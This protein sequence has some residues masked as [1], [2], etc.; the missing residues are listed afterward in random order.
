MNYPGFT[1]PVWCWLR[2]EGMK[3]PFLGLPV[4]IPRFSGRQSVATMR[5]F[6]AGMPWPQVLHSWLLLDSHDTTRF[7]T[8]TGSLEQQI[9]GVG[10]QMT[11]PGV[12]MVFAGDELGLEGD[13]GEDGRRTMPWDRLDAWDAELL[14]EYRRLIDLRRSHG[15]LARGGIRYAHVAEDAI[16]YLREIREERLLC[17]AA[18]ADH[19]PIRLPLDL[20]EADE[21]DTLHGVDA[22]LLDGDAIL[23]AGGPAF[24]VWKLERSS[25]G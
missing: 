3:H 6:R 18:R 17:L 20:L 11:T 2:G 7:R 19:A 14:G 1:L 13:W 25:R 24:S 5:A 21:L 12:P 4:P 22:T 8:V 16:A 10:L 9:V 15:A 23:P